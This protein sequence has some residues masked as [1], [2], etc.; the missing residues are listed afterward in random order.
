[1]RAVQGHIE[2]S[3]KIARADQKTLVFEKVELED[4]TCRT[5]GMALKNWNDKYE[6]EKFE[7]CSKQCSKC[8]KIFTKSADLTGHL[9]SGSCGGSESDPA[10]GNPAPVPLPLPEPVVVPDP[11][12]EPEPEPEP[13]PEPII[14]DKSI[15]FKK[16]KLPETFLN[17]K[18]A[19]A[20]SD[21]AA[22]PQSRLQKRRK[23]A[24][25][26]AAAIKKGLTDDTV[27]PTPGSEDVTIVKIEPE[28]LTTDNVAA[29]VSESTPIA[30]LLIPTNH[31][32]KAS[33]L[34]VRPEQD[35]T[36]NLS[37][38]EELDE[39]GT[40]VKIEECD[41]PDAASRASSKQTVPSSPLSKSTCE[42]C[43]K[44]LACPRDKIRHIESIHKHIRYECPKCLKLFSSLP[45]M[46]KHMRKFHNVLAPEFRKM[47]KP[48]VHLTE[49]K[50]N[51][52]T[53]YAQFNLSPDV[54]LRSQEIEGSKNS[55]CPICSKVY[56]TKHLKYHIDTVHR[57]LR[58]Q[59]PRCSMSYAER[60]LITKHLQNHHLIT[61]TDFNNL[62][63]KEINYEK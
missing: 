1:M 51:T 56:E 3:H 21:A 36:E 13:I 59:C 11:E 34:E 23:S 48:R 45:N 49:S 18:S 54:E 38:D 20:I 52:V 15:P 46:R 30:P 61:R 44:D 29:D 35:Q 25:L 2:R 19:T 27:T 58:Y 9:S 32:P 8:Y 60:K 28:E 31:R 42:Y 55:I 12:P 14:I 26:A 7:L 24:T 5:C 39:E 22:L 62:V 50:E 63:F 6:H 57:R 41:G 40:C 10:A 37:P 43:N 4:C 33:E 53:F 17:T 16:R 47:E